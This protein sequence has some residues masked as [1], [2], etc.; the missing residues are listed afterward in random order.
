MDICKGMLVY[1]KAG[2]DKGKL[3]LVLNT[4]NDFVYLT[5]GD[6]RRVTKPK[7]KK[8]KHVNKTNRILELDFDNVSDSCV[9]RAL[10]EYSER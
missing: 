8:L 2:R 4:E 5:D 9:R 7:K 10:S 1:S 6:T 3:F